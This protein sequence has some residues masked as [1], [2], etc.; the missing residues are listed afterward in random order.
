M[1]L[2]MV[3]KSHT[4]RAVR[5]SPVFYGWVIWGVATL[6]FIASSPGQ[7]FTTSL[8]IDQYIKEFGLGRTGVSTLYG[9]GT[10]IAAL[11]LTWFGRKVDQYGNRLTSVVV[12]VVF[13]VVVFAVSLINGPVTLFLGFIALRALGYGAIPLVNSTAIAQWFWKRRGR[14]MSLMLVVFSVFQALFV[15]F[16]Q[17]LIADYGWREVW[18]LMAGAVAVTLLPVSWLLM[19]DS[20]EDFGLLPDGAVPTQTN[21]LSSEDNWTLAEARRTWIFWIF[22]AGRIMSPAWGT[23]LII[24]QMSLF[25]VVGHSSAVTAQIYS[26]TAFVSAGVALLSG[27]MVDRTLPGRVLG[28][29]LLALISAMALAMVMTEQWMLVFYAISFGYV[30]GNGAVFDGAVWTNLFGRQHQ[31]TIRGFVATGTIAGTSVGPILFGLSYDTFGNYNAVLVLG[32]A[33]ATVPMVMSFFT[34]KPRRR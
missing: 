19:R 1:K 26:M 28:F 3:T 34:S 27:V 15:P 10:F 29:Q 24:H 32:I 17:D 12:S 9:L 6:G 13:V 21:S 33:L 23:G 30:I 14:M 31:G 22:M 11:S 20:P 25:A 2:A 4:S 18:V 7:S 8:F 5:Y 16:L